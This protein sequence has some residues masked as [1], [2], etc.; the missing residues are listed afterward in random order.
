MRCFCWFRTIISVAF[1]VEID[2][3]TSIWCTLNGYWCTECY[4]E[5]TIPSNGYWWSCYPGQFP[6]FCQWVTVCSYPGSTVDEATCHAWDPQHLGVMKSSNFIQES[7][8]SYYLRASSN[9]SFSHLLPAVQLT[10]TWQVSRSMSGQGSW[11]IS[12]FKKV[13]GHANIVFSPGSQGLMWLCLAMKFLECKVRVYHCVYPRAADKSTSW[14]SVTLGPYGNAMVQR[15]S[16]LHV[17]PL[18]VP[19]SPRSLTSKSRSF[20]SPPVA[21]LYLAM[22]AQSTLW[23]HP[24]YKGQGFI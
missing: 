18:E 14:W 10:W 23:F 1:M 15:W 3:T 7:K 16:F 9:D 6:Q 2:Q 19:T 8:G 17:Y 11:G 12:G 5:I 13:K 24:F 21:K 4:P 22:T 20:L